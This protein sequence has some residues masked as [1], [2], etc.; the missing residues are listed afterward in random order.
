[1]TTEKKRQADACCIVA[2]LRRTAPPPPPST[3]TLSKPTSTWLLQSDHRKTE[4]DLKPSSAYV[5]YRFRKLPGINHNIIDGCSIHLKST[6]A[7]WQQV[8]VPVE[9]LN[10]ARLICNREM[11]RPL[12]LA[13]LL[14]NSNLDLSLSYLKT[15][16]FAWTRTHQSDSHL[17]RCPCWGAWEGWRRWYHQWE[18]PR[19]PTRQPERWKSPQ[20]GLQQ[21]G[22]YH[23]LTSEVWDP[24]TIVWCLNC[25][26]GREKIK[27]LMFEVRQTKKK[28]I[29]VAVSKLDRNL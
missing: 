16:F 2:K 1:M 10:V 25:K 9:R 13:S 18:C 3:F 26:T 5:I 22:K 20:S 29:R 24:K 4:M 15:F 23:N 11:C 21:T 8:L 14:S 27:S 12:Y 6:H 19:P 7:I 28:K 17:S